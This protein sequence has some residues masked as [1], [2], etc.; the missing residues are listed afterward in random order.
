[1]VHSYTFD[2]AWKDQGWGNKKG[3]FYIVGHDRGRKNNMSASQEENEND[4]NFCDG[5]RIV[6][7]SPIAD[8][9]EKHLR[10]VFRPRIDET[11]HLWYICGGGG[12][13]T[14][15]FRRMFLRALVFDD[16]ERN[17]SRNFTKLSDAGVLWS[18]DGSYVYG[19][20]QN[21]D[22][23]L[24]QTA[25]SE[26]YPKMLLH[27]ARELLSQIDNPEFN[28]RSNNNHGDFGLKRLL[29]DYDIPITRGSLEALEGIAQAQ[30]EECRMYQAE[31]SQNPRL[32]VT[33]ET[34]SDDDDEEF[35]RFWFV[36]G[37]V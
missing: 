26:F 31:Q 27:V 9:E 20:T 28:T 30:I 18:A 17:Y 36:T 23:K 3:R 25:A 19:D 12:G 4:P 35:N 16:E 8:H 15:S 2:L 37:G 34:D 1:M 11:Y 6:Y 24:I 7:K 29:N 5:G 14:L 33:H 13:H 22:R 21:S 32:M 10:I